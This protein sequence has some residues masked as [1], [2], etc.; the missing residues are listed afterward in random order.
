MPTDNPNTPLKLVVT[1][2]AGYV[3]SVCTQRLLEAGHQVV[4]V[5]DLS[6]GHADAV[7]DGARFIEGD[8]ADT[9]RTLLAEGFDGVLHFAAKSL[10]GES[11]QDPARYW[12]GN[13]V[14]SLKLLDAMREHGTPRLVFSS[15]AAT[16]GEPEVSPIAETAP[17][18]PTNTYGATKLAVDNAI[19]TYARA[20]GLAAVSLRYF[21]VAGA[22]GSIGE[23]HS[24]ETHLI[25]LVLQVV[26]GDRERIQIYG[27]D[28]P[29]EDGTAVRDYIHVADLADAHLLALRHATAG[30]HRIYNLGNG[31]G[32]S[33]RQVIEACREVTGHPVPAVVAPRRAGDPAVLVAASD[34][35]RAELG[36]QPQRADLAGI[37]ADAW[38]F[39]QERRGAANPA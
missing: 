8:A 9:L 29:T 37:V 21:N 6:T 30:E 23:R 27:E 10:V 36:W 3:G 24:T 20:H 26:T 5:D 11:M 33:V 22:Y 12:H 4:V 1:G 16:Y 19:T 28:Y 35:A 13:V 38:R 7:P 14:T 17:T 18:Q 32:F 15:T 34:R 25:P 2:G 39:T 31:T